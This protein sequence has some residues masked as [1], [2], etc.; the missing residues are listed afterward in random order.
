MSKINQNKN[1][2]SISQKKAGSSVSDSSKKI[3]ASYLE[4]G[5]Y[6]RG[7]VLLINEASSLI[8]TEK[9]EGF[10]LEIESG[11]TIQVSSTISE[12]K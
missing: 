2:S 6:S 7:I 5:F 9:N 3:K 10:L 1:C 4:K 8:T 11:D 12:N